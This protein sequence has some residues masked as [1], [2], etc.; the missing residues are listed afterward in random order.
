MSWKKKKHPL[1][2][3][4]I[5]CIPKLPWRHSQPLPDRIMRSE[6]VMCAHSLILVLILFFLASSP[7]EIYHP[8][9]SVALFCRYDAEF[10]RQQKRT[11]DECTLSLPAPTLLSA[12]ARQ[13]H[14]LRRQQAPSSRMV[15]AV[16]IRLRKDSRSGERREDSL[17][18]HPQLCSAC[19]MLYKGR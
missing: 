7:F 5:S 13:N 17:Q 19:S 4:I 6:L 16:A 14:R 1:K 9:P 11:T 15:L 10:T 8:F 2:R 12:R 3:I 18:P